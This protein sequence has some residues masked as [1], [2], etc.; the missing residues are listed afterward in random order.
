[1][2]VNR[3]LPVNKMLRRGSR[4]YRGLRRD[5]MKRSD[6]YMLQLVGENRPLLRNMRQ[7]MFCQEECSKRWF[8][9]ALRR[10]SNGGEE[11]LRLHSC[12]I[13]AH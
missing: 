11:E 6:E 4:E 2:E 5:Q 9:E 1:M 7:A 12:K 10:R 8:V 3:R 13:L